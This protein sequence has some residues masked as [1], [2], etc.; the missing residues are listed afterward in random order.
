[1]TFLPI[2]VRE[3]QVAARRRSTFQMRFFGA[4]GAT[5]LGG[6][7]LMAST[8]P[9]GLAATGRGLFA[10]LTT[11]ALGMA[12]ISG[13]VLTADCLSREKREGTLGFLFLTDLNGWDVV[14]GKLVALGLVP[15]QI[16]L[17]FFPIVAMS[18][19]L[20]GVTS[21][22]FWRVLCVVVVTL[23]VSLAV[24]IWVSSRVTDDRQAAGASLLLMAGLVGVPYLLEGICVRVPGWGGGAVLGVLSPVGLYGRAMEAR[25]VL[26]GANFGWGIAVQAG[27]GVALVGMAGWRVKRSWRVLDGSDARRKPG[28]RWVPAF[29][30]RIEAG[31]QARWRAE[32]SL[33]WLAWQGSWVRRAAWWVVTGTVVLGVALFGMSLRQ[34][35][36]VSWELPGTVVVAGWWMLKLMLAAHTVYSLHE[37]FRNGMMELLLVTPVSG[38]KMWQGHIAAVRGIFLWPYLVMSLLAVGLGVG[39]NWAKGGDWPSWVVMVV[40]GAVPATIQAVVNALDFFAIAYHAAWWALNHDRPGKALLRTVLWVM[41]LPAMFCGVGRFVVD[42]LVIA[43]A[44]SALDRFRDLARGWYTPKSA[45]AIARPPR[46]K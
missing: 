34:G 11:V 20:G 38:G 28:A 31:Q 2:V 6:V 22:E 37:L 16:L 21:A 14:A 25:H 12:L 4:V 19:F 44:A 1:M 40:W 15:F 24:G 9:G 29:W 45:L 46:L 23:W 32:G 10:S 43:Q 27:I 3:L 26:G 17:S 41:V 36:R 5:L 42:L 7:F 35:P 18:V 8:L 13:A 33:A 39:E 30:R